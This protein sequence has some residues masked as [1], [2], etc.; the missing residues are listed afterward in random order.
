MDTINLST[1]SSEKGREEFQ[2]LIETLVKRS[3]VDAVFKA[4][5]IDHP[6]EAIFRETGIK[7][8]LPAHWRL[9]VNDQ[10]DPL[11]L[12]IKLPVNEENNVELTDEELEAVA[13]GIK[14]PNLH[15]IFECGTSSG[16][17]NNG[18]QGE[19]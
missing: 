1:F 8:D 7:V 9:T 2:M 5:F 16:T 18:N 14:P 19:I 13:G 4:S 12:S 3:S 11:A 10:A 15:C 6:R 17:G